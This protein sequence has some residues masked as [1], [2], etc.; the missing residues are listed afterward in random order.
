MTRTVDLRRSTPMDMD[1]MMA[2]N[3]ELEGAYGNTVDQFGGVGNSF[4]SQARVARIDCH[5]QQ[6]MKLAKRLNS[7]GPLPL[8]EHGFSVIPLKFVNNKRIF[9]NLK[10]LTRVLAQMP[11]LS[12]LWR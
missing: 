2:I 7:T 10:T 1:I 6:S 11:I 4:R 9:R 8:T 5:R 12:P 3:R